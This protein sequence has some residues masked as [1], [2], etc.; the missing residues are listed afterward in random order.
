L[1]PGAITRMTENL[2]DPN[3]RGRPDQVSPAVL[4]LCS[5]DAPQGMILQAADG[6]FS[7]IEVRAGEALDLGPDVTYEDFVTSLE[8]LTSPSGASVTSE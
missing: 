3:R 5:E 6:R 2:H 8:H 7:I 4:Y 1:A